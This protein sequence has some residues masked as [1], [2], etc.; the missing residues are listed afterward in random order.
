MPLVGWAHSIYWKDQGEAPPTP[1]VRR[2]TLLHVGHGFL[3][4]LFVNLLPW[5]ARMRL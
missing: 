1:G 5:I 4:V 2:V 3:L